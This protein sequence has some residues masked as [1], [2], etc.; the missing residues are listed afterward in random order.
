TVTNYSQT[1]RTDLPTKLLRSHENDDIF[2]I[3]II[4]AEKSNADSYEEIVC[5]IAVP[6]C[7]V[8]VRL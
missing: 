4:F 8:D 7:S 1:A 2:P 6:S 3:I 5:H